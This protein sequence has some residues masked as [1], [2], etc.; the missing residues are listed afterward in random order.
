MIQCNLAV[1]MAKRKVK[2]QA[3]LHRLTHIRKNTISDLYN[4]TASSISFQDLNAI[5]EAL[6]CKVS[7][8]IEHVPNNPPKDNNKKVRINNKKSIPI[9]EK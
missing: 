5:C 8:L 3:A 1:I 4:E 6:N 7:D 9:T 2:S